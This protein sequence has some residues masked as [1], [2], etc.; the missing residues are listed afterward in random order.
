[1]TDIGYQPQ[2]RQIEQALRLQGKGR[3]FHGSEADVP[4][5]NG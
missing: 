5:S 4:K 3:R 1:M 2:Y